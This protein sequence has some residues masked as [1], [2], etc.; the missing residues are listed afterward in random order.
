MDLQDNQLFTILK[1]EME[2]INSRLNKI[3]DRLKQLEMN[4][5]KK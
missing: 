4:G 2:Y 5:D 3:E 1:R